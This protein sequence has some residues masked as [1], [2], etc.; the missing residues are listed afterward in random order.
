MVGTPSRVELLGVLWDTAGNNH[1]RRLIMHR[2]QLLTGAAAAFG[3]I[4]STL[5][6]KADEPRVAQVKRLLIDIENREDGQYLVY[7]HRDGSREEVRFMEC[8]TC[9]TNVEF[10]PGFGGNESKIRMKYRGS[11]YVLTPENGNNE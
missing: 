9:L 6:L 10:I 4:L 11:S 1:S 5:G 3:S 2:R 7:L 8:D